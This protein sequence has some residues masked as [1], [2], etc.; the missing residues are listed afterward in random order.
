LSPN[1]SLTC[2]NRETLQKTE[3][4]L[5]Q[6]GNSEL[7]EAQGSVSFLYRGLY[8]EVWILLVTF[9]VILGLR[10][11]TDTKKDERIS[12]YTIKLILIFAFD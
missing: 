12:T 6:N 5:L 10:K 11:C 8:F 3:N 7:S 9:V 1:R 2:L 4:G